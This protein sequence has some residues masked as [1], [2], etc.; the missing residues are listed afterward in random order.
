MATNK[1]R[2]ASDCAHHFA[3]GF[4]GSHKCGIFWTFIS[5]DGET[6]RVHVTRDCKGVCPEWERRE[7]SDE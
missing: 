5:G 7:E 2:K 1:R 6:I 3:S 4:D